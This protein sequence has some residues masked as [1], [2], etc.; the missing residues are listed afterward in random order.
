MTTPCLELKQDFLLH[1]LQG[2]D[3][4]NIFIPFTCALVF[5]ILQSDSI[6]SY[7]FS[8]FPIF[9]HMHVH[10]YTHHTRTTTALCFANN[11]CAVNSYGIINVRRQILKLY[12]YMEKVFL[13]WPMIKRQHKQ[14]SF[15]S[16]D[17]NHNTPLPKPCLNHISSYF[18]ICLAD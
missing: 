4:F 11:A 9:T 5:A 8:S 10:T 14:S 13:F 15:V 3:H 7:S 1:F 2:P 17:H 18:F 16:P 6:P 12:L